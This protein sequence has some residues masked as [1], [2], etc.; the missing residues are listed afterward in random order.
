M[1]RLPDLGPLWPRR[2]PDQ[3]AFVVDDIGAGIRRW[4][5]LLGSTDDDWLVYTYNR[6][7][8]PDLSYRGAP[9]DFSISL[10]LCGSSP[11][12]E[13]IENVRGD[14]LYSEWSR[15]GEV[16]V[17]HL[18]WF[19]SDLTAVVADLRSRGICDVQAGSGYGA[20]G[21]GAFAYFELPGADVVLELIEIPGQRRPSESV[22]T[23]RSARH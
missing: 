4:N 13:L 17:H 9:A 22:P 8:V 10:A 14:S 1:P 20:G 3:I 7:T 2:T 23:P 15:A 5:A 12:V 11:Q 18:G 19:V 21:D 6:E 16:G